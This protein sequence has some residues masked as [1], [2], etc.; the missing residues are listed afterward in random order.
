MQHVLLLGGTTEASRLAQ[1]L[2]GAGVRA[3]FSYAGRTH[4]PLAQPLPTRVGGFGGVDG[5]RTYLQTEAIT[6]VIDATHPF[7]AQI[8]RHAV[9]ACCEL[10][11]PLLALVRPA[12]QAQAGDRWQ[13]VPDLAAAAAA[14]PAHPVRVFLA[15]GRQQAQSFL[16]LRLHWYLLRLVDPGFVLPD[17]QGAVVVDRGPFTLANDLALMHRHRITHVV[18]KNAGGLGAQA[19]LAA[20][21]QL[22]CPV[23]LID[24][25]QLPARPAVGTVEE[26]LRWLVLQTVHGTERGV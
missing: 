15:I 1:A 13:P 23:V 2:A 24:R 16:D 21:R 17:S 3:V 8:S 25:P 18:A 9:Q 10:A 14:L 22:G 5:L 12:W 19:K 11:L 4:A 20:A 7:A 6:H 26:A